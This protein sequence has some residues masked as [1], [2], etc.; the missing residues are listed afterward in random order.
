MKNFRFIV[1]ACSLGIFLVFSF[2]SFGQ[3]I[4]SAAF[5]IKVLGI[6]I[7]NM[8]AKRTRKDSIEIYD[9]QSQ[10]SFWFFGKIY[11]NHQVDCIF[12]NGKFIESTV[13]SQTNKGDFLSKIFWKKDHY[14]VQSE[15]YK[16]EN[17]TPISEEV[18]SCISKLFFTKPKDGDII[19][20]ETYGLTSPIIEV[21]PNVFQMTING[22]KNQFY[23][24][25]GVLDKVMI[26]NPIKNFV[27]HRIY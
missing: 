3:K 15:T 21:E 13:D 7:G 27:M 5:Q 8:E 2:E 6:S 20:S 12:R 26:E 11:L 14:Q 4:D 16:Y 25:N 18:F 23:Y 17:S 1:L 22:N 19:L 10:V 9:L 24:E